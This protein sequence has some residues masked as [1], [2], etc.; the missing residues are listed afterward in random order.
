MLLYYAPTYHLSTCISPKILRAADLVSSLNP[1]WVS[2]MVFTANI[3]TSKWK[4]CIKIVLKRLLVAIESCS[5][6]ARDP[7]ASASF[8]Q[9]FCVIFFKL[10]S[11]LL[12]SENFVAPSAS[13]NRQYRP[14]EGAE[15]YYGSYRNTFNI[16]YLYYSIFPKIK[17]NSISITTS[18]QNSFKL[19]ILTAPPFPLF[20]TKGSTRN[21]LVVYFSQYFIAHSTVPSLLPSD[22]TRTSYVKLGFS[23]AFFSRNSMHSSNITGSR[24]SSS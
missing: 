12:K 8:F 11:S 17:Q 6:C 1:H 18:R 10:S 15:F 24:F 14:D 2:F 20:W 23:F 3:H 16:H 21:L 19:T 9:S 5:K 4:P 13:A 22:T 7:I